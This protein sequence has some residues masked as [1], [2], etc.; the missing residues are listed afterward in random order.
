MIDRAKFFA[1]VRTSPFNG[2]LTQGQVDGMSAILDEWERRKLTDL[3]WLA[4][5]LAT[6]WW[7]CDRT[8]QPIREVGRGKGR[9]YGKRDPQSGQFYYGR[10]FVQLTWR[11]NYEAMGKLI[12]ADLVNDPDRA[13]E[14]PIASAIL[15]LGMTRGIFTGRKLAD[16]LNARATD[17]INAR[18]IINGT[19]KASI[20][21]GAAKQFYAD[22]VSADRKAA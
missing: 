21:A 1:G 3:R 11:R 16:Y 8:M 22:L 2:R 9:A 14:L 13:L 7:E 12:G 17:W 20:I 5:M 18:R 15:F 4:Y 10:G 6:V 19:D